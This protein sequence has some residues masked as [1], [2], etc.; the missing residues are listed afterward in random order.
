MKIENAK[1]NQNHF[2]AA[3][4]F[5][6]V[7]TLPLLLISGCTTMDEPTF[8]AGR[9][10]SY[11]QHEQKNGL[12]IGIHPITDKQEVEGIF[13]AN[14]L[15]KG[16]LPILVVAENQSPSNSF[17]MAKEQLY[18]LNA[19]TGTT[20]N[21]QRKDIEH[22][23]TVT[24]EIIESAF[25]HGLLLFTGEKL[26]SDATVINYN[27]ADKEF[28][29]K[30]L[31]PSEKASGFVYFQIPKYMPTA[32]NYHIVAKVKNSTTG[33]VIVF[34]FPASLSLPQ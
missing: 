33:E 32:G 2:A 8:T 17:V 1:T 22:G 10:D 34:D 15:K 20:S 31:G 7:A 21:S 30:T 29:S 23:M 4:F 3:F 24:G 26:V 16:I 9:A 14:L 18:V 27:L 19:A 5:G 6:F 13:N 28:Y 11:P 25:S 12:T